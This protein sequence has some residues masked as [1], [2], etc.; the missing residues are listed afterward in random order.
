MTSETK[1]VICEP[2]TVLYAERYVDTEFF[3]R[4]MNFRK[5]ALLHRNF[6]PAINF[7]FTIFFLIINLSDGIW[8][9]II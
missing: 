1:K 8:Q 4:R 6:I 5:L 9:C 7:E 3:S 2:G